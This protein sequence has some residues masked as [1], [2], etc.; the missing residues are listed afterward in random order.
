MRDQNPSAI[1]GSPPAADLDLGPIEARAALVAAGHSLEFGKALAA[2][3][4]TLV[5]EVRRL[6][7]LPPGY[8]YPTR[9]A[10]TDFL[11][12]RMMCIAEMLDDGCAP[13]AI[14]AWMSVDLEQLRLLDMTARQCRTKAGP[15]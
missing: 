14:A 12:Y 8:P 5:A 10:H 6:R 13:A 11:Y 9:T 3:V 2:D 7:V 1:S 15:L 4:T